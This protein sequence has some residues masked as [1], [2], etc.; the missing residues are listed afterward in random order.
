[1][2]SWHAW[3]SFIYAFLS[4]SW[5]ISVLFVSCCFC[6]WCLM[7]RV[8]YV[9]SPCPHGLSTRILVIV[10]CSHLSRMA[11]ISCHLTPL[12]TELHIIWFFPLFTITLRNVHQFC[13][14]PLCKHAG[15]K[16]TN[17]CLVLPSY[18]WAR[19][20]LNVWFSMVSQCL[21]SS[22]QIWLKN[23]LEGDNRLMLYILH[24]KSALWTNSPL[25]RYWRLFWKTRKRQL[26]Q[27]W[28]TP[29][30]QDVLRWVLF[31]PQYSW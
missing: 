26:R 9:I 19:R 7:W 18:W 13:S 20:S 21:N 29:T 1:M 23:W 14:P 25:S 10:I 28:R 8:W 3:N 30:I 4:T 12:K 27:F 6:N 17:G 2:E 31:Y 16:F 22:L 15:E 11:M 5:N 24:T